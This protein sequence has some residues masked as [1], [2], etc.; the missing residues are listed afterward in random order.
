MV[1]GDTLSIKVYQAVAAALNK[2]PDRS[3]VLSDTGNFPTDLYMVD[4]LIKTMNRS[5]EL[6]LVEP[7]EVADALDDSVA[8]LL[9]THIDYRTGRMHDMQALT[10]KAQDLCIV[11]VWD[12]AHSAGAVPVD[13]T[14]CQAEFAV[15]CTYKYLN[16]GPG[17]P[18]FI[19]V[20]PDLCRDA[21]SYTHLTLPTICSV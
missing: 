17:A 9:L 16:G 1:I 13:L 6:K 18:A 8:V 21:V 12:L 14:A 3:V 10:K 19:Y 2:N 15:G 20:R 7:E 11:T 5:L 4:G